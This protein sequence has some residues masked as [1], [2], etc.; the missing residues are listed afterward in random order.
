[1][2]V[3]ALDKRMVGIIA[4]EIEDAVQ[5]VAQKYDINIKRGNGRFSAETATLK[6]EITTKGA[7]GQVETSDAKYFKLM[8]RG[9]GLQAED[10]GKDIIFNGTQYKIVGLK[11]SSFKYPILVKSARDGKTYKLR[12][13]SVALALS[14]PSPVFRA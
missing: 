4:K 11:P 7:G 8:A 2:K 3:T 10:L 12:A 14:R 6:L 1:M 5:A 13:E 9:Y